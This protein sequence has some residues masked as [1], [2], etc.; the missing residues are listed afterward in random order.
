M[1]RLVTSNYYLNLMVSEH[2]NSP[3]CTDGAYKHWNVHSGRL[4]ANMLTAA[5]FIVGKY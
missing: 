3:L 5:G 4:V 2:R 1:D